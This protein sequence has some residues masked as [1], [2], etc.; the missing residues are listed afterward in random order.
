MANPRLNP[1]ETEL[2]D[3]SETDFDV[4]DPFDAEDL[5]GIEEDPDGA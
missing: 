5:D 1:D 3:G 4:F 2:I